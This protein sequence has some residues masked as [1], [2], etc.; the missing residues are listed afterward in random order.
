MRTVS[1]ACPQSICKLG[2]DSRRR[3]RSHS[4]QWRCDRRGRID[5]PIGDHRRIR[6]MT[7]ESGTAPRLQA[8][9]AFFPTRSRFASPRRKATFLDRMIAL[10]KGGA[11]K[12]PNEI[13]LNILFAA[14]TLIFVFAV[15]TIGSTPNL[16]NSI[17]KARHFKH[18]NSRD[19]C[20]IEL[21][22]GRHIELNFH[23]FTA[24]ELRS[25]FADHFDIEDLRGLDLFHNPFAPDPRWNPASLMVDNQFSNELERLEETYATS[26][27]FMERTT[28]LLLVACR[29]QTVFPSLWRQKA[30]AARDQGDANDHGD[31]PA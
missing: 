13:A 16:G 15:A 18:D 21:C 22:N 28:H 26:S 2:T 19:R 1:K 9:P 4:E 7:R 6:A 5:R 25:Y 11:A 30:D 27:G 12:T 20:E 8:A 14:L 24:S 31:N 17:E 23:L 29:R 10:S 3:R